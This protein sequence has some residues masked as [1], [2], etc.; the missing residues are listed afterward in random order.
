MQT[1]VHYLAPHILKFEIDFVKFIYDA[2]PPFTEIDLKKVPEHYPF[3]ELILTE[4]FATSGTSEVNALMWS[5]E[6]AEHIMNYLTV[7]SRRMPP[8]YT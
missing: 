3:I 7:L 1:K 8:L 2:L 4:K 6:E 5:Y